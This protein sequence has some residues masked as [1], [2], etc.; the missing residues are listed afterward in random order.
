MSFLLVGLGG[1]L[2]SVTRYLIQI[3]LPQS[4]IPL[5]T[6]FVNTFGCFILGCINS[7]LN[8]EQI[9]LSYFLVIGFLGA[10]T[11]FSALTN[12]TV[13]IFD[14]GKWTL[15]LLN[16]FLHLSLGFSALYGGRWFMKLIS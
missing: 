13:M 14:D 4:S 9:E 7:K 10:F 6:L 16:I 8:H 15:A 3:I 12:E 5:G 2:G 11:T 1:F